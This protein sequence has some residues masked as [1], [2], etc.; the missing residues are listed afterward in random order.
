MRGSNYPLPG[1]QMKELPWWAYVHT[2]GTVQV[3]R[4][5]GS[6][7]IEEALTSP[8]VSRVCGPFNA[9]DRGDAIVKAKYNFN[10]YGE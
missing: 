5:F 7:D 1:V 8:F 3:K 9:V 10:L 6:R 2:N 4:Y